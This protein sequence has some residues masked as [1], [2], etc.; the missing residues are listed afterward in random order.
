MKG[1]IFMTLFALPFFGVGVFMLWSVSNTFVNAFEMRGWHPVEARI[2]DAGYH[3]SSGDDSDTYE[4]YA[5]YSYSWF[6]QTFTG[7]RV[8]LNGGSDNIGDYQQDM[9][10]ML[11]AAWSSQQPVTVW[12]NPDNPAESIIDRSIRW[13]LIGFKSIFLFTFGGVGLGLLIAT[14]RTPKEKDRSLPQYR[15]KPWLLNDK[16]QSETI[17]SSSK[18]TM[19]AAWGFAAFWNLVSA[20]TPFIAYREVTESQNYIALVALLFP[21]IGIVLIAWAVRRTREWTRFGATPVVLDPFPGS[22]GGH[23]GGTIALNL[24][25]DSA[26]KFLLTL[27]NIHSYMSGSGDDRSRKEDALWQDEIVAHA[28]SSGTGTRL[29]FRYDIPEGLSESDAAPEG[30]AYDLWRLNVRADIPGADFDRDFEIP[31]YATARSSVGIGDY[32]LERAKADQAKIYDDVIQDDINIHYD[33]MGKKLSYPMGRNFVSNFLGFVIGGAFTAVGVWLV[34]TEGQ[35]VFGSIF[36]GVGALVAVSAFYMMFR[37]LDVT[38]E[39]DTIR[40]RRRWLGIPL[41]TREMR[42]SDFYR[43]ELDRGM[44]SQQG[45]KHVTWYKVSAIDRNANEILLGEGFKGKAAA[46]AAIRLLSRE[47]GLTAAA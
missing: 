3:R 8:G 34:V 2:L 46:R 26:H 15:D 35:R 27:T 5:R 4:A 19:W 12:V 20:P 25:F 31:V 23:V 17:R 28:E 40:S 30:E 38:Q 9:G 11:G 45:G 13:G 22:I 1:R 7:T 43:F 6:G 10:R 36:G 47:L 21:L 32:Q 39:G 18:M 24:P 16:W 29:V 14:W 33:G 37:S 42:K 44:K 41:R